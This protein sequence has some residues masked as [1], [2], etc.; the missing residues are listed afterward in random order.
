MRKIKGEIPIGNT[1]CTFSC[2]EQYGAY[3]WQKTSR[4]LTLLNGGMRKVEQVWPA[5]GSFFLTEVF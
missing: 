3:H 1:T 4:A 2:T 5:S